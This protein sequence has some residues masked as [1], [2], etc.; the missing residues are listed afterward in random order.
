MTPKLPAFGRA[1]IKM[2]GRPAGRCGKR[3]TFGYPEITPMF[4]SKGG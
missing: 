3:F 4:V 2:M 1:N